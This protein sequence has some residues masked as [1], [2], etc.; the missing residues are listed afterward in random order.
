M[1]IS[2]SIADSIMIKQVAKGSLSRSDI[3]EAIEMAMERERQPVAIEDA[4]MFWPRPWVKELE[5]VE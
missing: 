5:K 4:P 3:L 2:E 1:N